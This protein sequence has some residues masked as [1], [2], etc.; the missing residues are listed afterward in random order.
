MNLTGQQ[1]VTATVFAATAAVTMLGYVLLI[2]W[3]G[4]VGAAVANGGAVMVRNVVLNHLA[5]RRLG[6]RVSLIRSL[7]P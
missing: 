2:P 6:I 1:H 5:R 4:M 7:R 3:L